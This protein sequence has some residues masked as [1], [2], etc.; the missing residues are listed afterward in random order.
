MLRKAKA[1]GVISLG[2]EIDPNNLTST[3][4]HVAHGFTLRV[5]ESSE[6]CM[7]FEGRM[8]KFLIHWVINMQFAQKI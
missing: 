1:E 8:K 7:T 5:P 6:P 3:G 4:F 2:A